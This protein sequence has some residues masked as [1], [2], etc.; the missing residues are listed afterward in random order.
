MATTKPS[1]ELV[2]IISQP[3]DNDVPTSH[4]QAESGVLGV[5]T[6]DL[7]AL[8]NTLATITVTHKPKLFSKGMLRLWGIVRHPESLHT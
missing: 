8:E 3:A 4:T 2:E 7:K 1:D 5:Q 6:Y